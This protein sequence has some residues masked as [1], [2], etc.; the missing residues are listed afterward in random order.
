MKK[1][2]MVL[3]LAGMLCL[4]AIGCGGQTDNSQDAVE[5]TDTEVQQPETD[6]EQEEAS[7]GEDVTIEFLYYADDTQKAIIESACAAYEDSHPGIKIEQ[8]VVPADGSITTTIATLASSNDLPDISYMAEA[9]VIKYADA[10]LLYSLD[11]AVADGTIG[12]K[13]DSVT[14]RGLD[15]KIYGIGLSNQLIFMYY[16]K[17]IF[18]EYKIAYPS[19]SVEDAWEWDEFVE[20]AKQ[21]TV[22]ANGKH[23]DEA[24]FDAAQTEQYGVAFNS[25]Y[26]FQY[27]WS[28][29]ANG[30]GIVSADGT[31]LLWDKPESIEG[32][33]KIADLFNK[34]MVAPATTSSL[35]SS[36]GSADKAM[37]SGDVAMYINGS[38]DLSNVINADKEAGVNYGIAVLPK[39]KEAVT[40]NCGGPAVM[41]N[42]T[43]HP[44]EVL[45]FYAYMMDPE[46]VVDIL[47]TGAWLPNEAAWYTDEDKIALWTSGENITEEAKEVIL[48]Y[49]NT[50]GAIAQWPVYYVPGWGDM[51]SVSD[52]VMDSVWNGSS[53]VEEALSPV[54]DEI[55][56]NF[57][58]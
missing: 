56:T 36:I 31:E 52:S 42:T 50:E 8:T 34:D 18:D 46:R 20:I 40:M 25:M 49:T 15:G 21:L 44:K 9:D 37:I 27:M 4:T 32:I 13:L 29:Y 2:T 10:G 33:Q 26:Q 19:T 57:A 51:M 28:A 39:M 48:S 43:E 58:Q 6:G 47:K 3:L 24:G 55:R 23:P 38:W 5:S 30:G 22:D 54:M 1:K 35:V 53:T 11:D 17:D 12:E 14:I 7:A 16:N 41:F 45:E